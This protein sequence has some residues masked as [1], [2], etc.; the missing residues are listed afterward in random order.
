MVHLRYSIIFYISVTI[1][2]IL[3]IPRIAISQM[4]YTS[5]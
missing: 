2:I 1:S 4:A 3:L 5:A